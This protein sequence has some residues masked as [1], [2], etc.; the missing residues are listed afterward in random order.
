MKKAG[1]IFDRTTSESFMNG[2]TGAAGSLQVERLDPK[3]RLS[4]RLHTS[5]LRSTR[6]SLWNGFGLTVFER[7]ERD[8]K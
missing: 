8:G 4:V 1:H 2:T 7:R 3:A 5:G 6:S